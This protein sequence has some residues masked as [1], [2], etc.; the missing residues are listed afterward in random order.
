VS[1]SCSPGQGPCSCNTGMVP[2][3]SSCI[4]SGSVCCGLGGG[5]YCAVSIPSSSHPLIK[6]SIL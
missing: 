1:S 2:C 3:D 6:Q 4:P 5:T